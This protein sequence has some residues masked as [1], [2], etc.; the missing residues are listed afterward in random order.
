MNKKFF[1]LSLLQGV[2]IGLFFV[3]LYYWFMEDNRWCQILSI[4]F[5]SGTLGLN[6]ILVKI[7]E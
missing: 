4:A 3:T 2:F 6:R 5:F 7:N 1:W